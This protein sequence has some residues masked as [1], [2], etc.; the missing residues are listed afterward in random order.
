M[1]LAH[2]EVLSSTAMLVGLILLLGGCICNIS[3]ILSAR[4]P[5]YLLQKV[6]TVAR[7]ATKMLLLG[8][9]GSEVRC[10]AVSGSLFESDGCGSLPAEAKEVPALLQM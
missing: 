7:F 10:R 2:I 8:Q 4:E 9:Q 3:A 6:N 5:E 1:T